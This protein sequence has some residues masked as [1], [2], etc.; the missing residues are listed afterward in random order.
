MAKFGRA[1]PVLCELKRVNQYKVDVLYKFWAA[2]LYAPF[3]Q[4]PKLWECPV[5]ERQSEKL[6]VWCGAWTRTKSLSVVN[7]GHCC[8]NF[9]VFG[10]KDH[11]TECKWEPVW[12]LGG[13]VDE[14]EHTLPPCCDLRESKHTN[15]HR[16]RLG[17]NIEIHIIWNQLESTFLAPMIT[18]HWPWCKMWT[19]ANL[20][21]SNNDKDFQ[22]ST[23]K[24][25]RRNK[26]S[27]LYWAD[28]LLIPSFQWPARFS[29][30]ENFRELFW[31]FTFHS[32]SRVVFI[33]L[34]FLDFDFQ[35]FLFHFHFS[36]RVKG[37]KISPF[38]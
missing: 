37:K 10:G 24:H 14:S 8:L 36:K 38:S 25:K 6:K 23:D 30:L 21:T 15:T 22:L 12:T 1:S 18:Y 7:Q 35:S 26:L 17:T 5:S 28:C 20:F 9:W 3:S 33:S 13:G 4:F 27:F 19:C 16:R 11:K 32:R 29:N 34:S 2:F 31:N